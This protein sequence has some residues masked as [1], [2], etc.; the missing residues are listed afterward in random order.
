MHHLMH[1][2][3]EFWSYNTYVAFFIHAV[4]ALGAIAG[5]Q[6]GL[7]DRRHQ[8]YHPSTNRDMHHAR[9]DPEDENAD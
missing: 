5:I 1:I 7:E 4:L 3:L 2:Y 9:T 6:T 8:F